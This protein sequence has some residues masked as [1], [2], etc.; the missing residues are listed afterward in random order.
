MLSINALWASRDEKRWQ[1]ALDHYWQH[2]KPE[3]REL[4]KFMQALD[5]EWVG[6]LD[7]RQWYEFLR[8]KY[9]PWKFTRRNRLASNIKHLRRYEDEGKLDYLHS[10]TRKLF[11]FDAAQI[12][13][14]LEIATAIQGLGPAGASGLL[15][16]LLPK[17]FGC[18]DQFVVKALCEVQTL[19]ERPKVLAIKARWKPGFED[20]KDTEAILLIDIMRRKARELNALFRT[21]EWT[22]RKIDMIL[23]A[24]RNAESCAA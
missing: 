16:V 9:F 11:T 5:V 20:I 15:A 7:S 14:G 22:P 8:D 17:R 4:Y 18:A 12:S 13:K 23:W 6:R 1:D 3:N 24:S 19:P 21:D 10:I 2:V